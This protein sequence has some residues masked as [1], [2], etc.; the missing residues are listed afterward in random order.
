MEFKRTTALT[1]TS[2][3]VAC[4][5]VAC[6]KQSWNNP[7]P[8]AD[9][10]KNVIYSHFAERPKSLDP[11]R[12]Y[13]SNEYNFIG[14]I[15]E[16]PLHYDYLKRPYELVPLT[17]V[18]VPKPVHY[19]KDGNVLTNNNDA[20][21]IAYTEYEI[22]IRKGILYQPHPALA[23]DDSGEYLYHNLKPEDIADIEELGHFNQ[24]GFRE[25]TAA[26]YINQIKRLAHP[27]VHSPILS[28]MGKIIVGLKDL[29]KELE[30]H[31]NEKKLNYQSLQEMIKTY[32]A[33]F[34]DSSNFSEMIR[35]YENLVKKLQT[36]LSDLK[37][38]A[39]T[40]EENP[41]LLENTKS[42]SFWLKI[43]GGIKKLMSANTT[44]QKILT[45]NILLLKKIKIINN[46]LLA[47][48]DQELIAAQRTSLYIDLRKFE[49]KGVKQVDRYTYRIRVNKQY[50]Q[51][52][53]W[54][55]MPFFSPT[56]HEADKFYSQPG[57]KEKN[58]TM[59]WFP[60]GTGAYMLT[61]N[62][63]NSKMVL[64]RNPNYR[65]M[66]YPSIGTAKDKATGLLDDAG[67]LMPF[68]DKI[69]FS[70][71]KESIPI[72]NKFLQ[73]YYDAAGINSESFD[74]AVN[75]GQTGEASLSPSME[76]KGVK[77]VTTVR[78]SVYYFGFNM[79][80]KVVGG[81]DKRARHLRQAISIA[82]D[83]KDFIDIFINGR[84]IEAQ[85]PLPPGVYGYQAGKAGMNP[86]V[87]DWRDNRI[88][89]KSIEYAKKLLADVGY[90]DGIDSKT[91]EPLIIYMDL[92]KSDN[93][94]QGWYKKQFQ[95]IDLQ[96]EFRT[97]DY[98]QFQ[99]KMFNGK[100][101]I[102]SW[103][104]NADY[105]DPENFLFL[106]YGP[107]G[108]VKHKGENAA[109]YNNPEFN[110]L[111]KKME[112]IPNSPERIKIINRMIDIARRDA[113]WMWGLNPK[114]YVLYHGWY[115][116]AKP[117]AMS[118]NTLMYKRVVTSARTKSRINWNPPILWPIALLII[119]LILSA[120]PAVRVYKNKLYQARKDNS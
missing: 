106:L 50:P 47:S 66:K 93:A 78:M 83:H 21:S 81:Y 32:R 17:A 99:R 97:T 107:N 39:R 43:S 8:S 5:L 7:Y 57:L 76:K 27:Q 36:K 24:T 45:N 19:D 55:A 18:K 113:P 49:L 20:A 103:G 34:T 115:K 11:A 30:K 98:N 41:T 73:G 67:K 58:I 42:I 114:S 53:Y 51:L 40:L 69:V 9:K 89:R 48:L 95:K 16:P 44:K 28:I 71:D 15:Y 10:N 101:Q 35:H 86:Y 120:V 85:G 84:G 102:F 60:I 29:S 64:S 14:N 104:W 54:L 118:H 80:D 90:K 91:G 108:K 33:D 37:A 79:L 94:E 70:L 87:F 117:H 105:P 88:Q 23:K 68:T 2:L 96:V 65:G 100:A 63:P 74:Q 25:L 22:K 13:S 56:P 1:F 62:D 72:W 12:S 3:L 46:D 119:I 31:Q 52:L 82:M 38:L 116:N 110:R 6:D 75:I 112:T 59:A 111:F 4:L 26:D 109:N 92:A 77:M 61:K